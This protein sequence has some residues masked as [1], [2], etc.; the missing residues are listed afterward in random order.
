MVARLF[1]FSKLINML[2]KKFRTAWNI[3]A[4]VLLVFV[5]F[6]C[7]LSASA[8]NDWVMVFQ[9]ADGETME[10]PMSKVGSL[11]A[12][13][14]DLVLQIWQSDGQV[15]TINLNDEPCTTY[16]E[17]NLVIT[18]TTT[19]IT[20]P[21]EK[22]THYV[23]ASVPSGIDAVKSSQMKLSADGETLTLTNLKSEASVLLYNVAG[24]LLATVKPDA[25]S[26]A[27]ISIS[28]LPAGV[29]VVK[30]NDVTYKMT[31]R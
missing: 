4:K 15:M 27:V 16:S 14:D 18:T 29:Y 12:V 24:L 5:L 10:I 30:A 20:F 7:H 23:Y 9:N 31:K 28:N 25:A 6:H 3:I 2:Q 26:R 8:D 21:M 17:G 19:T 22:V 13:A 11:V 1:L